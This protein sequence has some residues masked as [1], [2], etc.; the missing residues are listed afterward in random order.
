MKVTVI[1]IKFGAFVKVSKVLEKYW[2][3]RKSE[4]A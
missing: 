1:P 4:E 3:N 2:K